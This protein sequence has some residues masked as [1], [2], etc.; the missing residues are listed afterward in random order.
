MVKIYSNASFKKLSDNFSSGNRDGIDQSIKTS[1]TKLATKPPTK[2]AVTLSIAF[3]N[4]LYLLELQLVSLLRQSLG[5]TKDTQGCF[6]EVLICD[7][8]SRPEVVAE[9]HRWMDQ[10]SLPI[11]HLW[12][13]DKGFRKNRLLNWGIYH[14]TS[15]Y[16]VFIDQDCLLHPEFLREHYLGQKA[17]AILCGRRMELTPFVS[18]LLNLKRVANGFIERNLWWIIP[19]SL[20]VK[21][22]NGGKG[23]YLTNPWMRKMANRKPRDIVGCNFSVHRS[24]L[25]AVNGFDWRYEAPGT[26][27]DSDI[28]YRLTLQGLTKIP[29]V[30][31]AVQYHVYHKLSS[32]PSVNDEIFKQVKAEGKAWTRFGLNEQLAEA[33]MTVSQLKI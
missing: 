33:G 21:D 19:L 25:L 11:K 26:G 6:F 24:D 14:S 17:G 7:D 1:A 4:N 2:P 16:I 10:S 18:K 8:G 31:K 30:G 29:F 9:V 5:R 22:A 27:E 13:E 3:Y 12:H 20:P 23:V 28:D 15:E 32:R